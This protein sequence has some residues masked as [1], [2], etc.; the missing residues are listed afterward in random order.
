MLTT[1]SLMGLSVILLKV[2]KNGL[3]ETAEGMHSPVLH[4][5]TIE[6]SVE[7]SATNTMG[8]PLTVRPRDVKLKNG[9][10]V[11][12]IVSSNVTFQLP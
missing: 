1:L 2:C 7:F 12:Q 3:R 6:K 4:T 8:K 9:R 10:H 5:R 11:P